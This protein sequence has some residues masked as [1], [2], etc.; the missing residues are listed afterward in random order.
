M[1]TLS[2]ALGERSYPIHVGTGLLDRADLIV[3]VLHRKQVAVVTNATVAPLFLERLAGALTR[4][5]VEVARIV[6]PDGEDHKDWPTLNAV[7]DALLEKRCGRD[8]TLVA[9]GGGVIGDLA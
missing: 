9:L 2:V 6:L 1:Q 4:D 3:P 8:T 7:F 5:G